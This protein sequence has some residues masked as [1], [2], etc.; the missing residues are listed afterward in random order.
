MILPESPQA[1]LGDGLLI[2]WATWVVTSGLPTLVTAA[3]LIVLILR[4]M[5]LWRQWRTGK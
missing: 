2:A 3:T 1:A 4:G 5:I